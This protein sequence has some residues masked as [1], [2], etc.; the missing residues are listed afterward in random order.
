MKTSK[1]MEPTNNQ[2]VTLKSS[3]KQYIVRSVYETGTKEENE[4]RATTGKT[5]WK[6]YDTRMYYCNVLKEGK[7]WGATRIF[8]EEQLIIK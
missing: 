1:N 4:I 8:R 7:A 6:V 3:G 5:F 2:I